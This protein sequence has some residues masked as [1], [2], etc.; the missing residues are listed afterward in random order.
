MF[1]ALGALL[2]VYL[3]Y[4]L[5]TGAVYAK[6]G[7]WGRSFSRDTDTTGYW[8]AIVS[9]GVLVLALFFVF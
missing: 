1:K 3:A 8:A 2:A 6:A 5:T 4:A 7:A 9:Y